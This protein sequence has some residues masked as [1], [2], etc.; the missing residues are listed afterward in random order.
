MHQP[1][2]KAGGA[3]IRSRSRSLSSGM[4]NLLFPPGC[5]SGP[6]DG[7][8]KGGVLRIMSAARSASMKTPDDKEISRDARK[9][10]GIDHA[11]PL[12]PW[13]QPGIRTPPAAP[14]AHG[15]GAAG[16]MP[17]ALVRT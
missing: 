11:K 14:W 16:V 12:E 5:G 6:G 7:V 15:G 8:R 13:T 17:Q 9:G 1:F 10:R 4:V 2:D 3:Q